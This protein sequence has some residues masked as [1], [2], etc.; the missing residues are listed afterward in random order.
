MKVT[1][2]VTYAVGDVTLQ[3]FYSLYL[4]DGDVGTA[5]SIGMGIKYAF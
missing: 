1:P 4:P 2:E 3:G 5:H